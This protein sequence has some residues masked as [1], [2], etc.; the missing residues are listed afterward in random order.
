MGV[1]GAPHGVNG[2][3]R[4]KS[5]AADPKALGAYGPLT[6]GGGRRVFAF[7][8][9]RPLKVDM[10]VGKLRGVATRDAAGALTG[11]E[12]FARRGQLPPPS[13]DEFYWADLVGLE[14]ETRDGV[15]LGRVAALSNHGA[16][17][18]LEIAPE[19]GGETRLMPFTRA[20]VPEI[21]FAGGQDRDRTAGRD[22]LGRRFPR[23]LTWWGSWPVG[24][25]TAS[26]SRGPA[27]GTIGVRVVDIAKKQNLW[28]WIPMIRIIPR[29]R[30]VVGSPCSRTEGPENTFRR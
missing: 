22:R 6:D 24:W 19:G 17:D 27:S 12:I 13:E 11:I 14:A 25:T 10:L 16:G 23:P 2:E 9:L 3:I 28:H 30:H 29:P 26:R 5:Y 21:D 20:V 18:I 7:E 8:R 1:F 4:I 15:R